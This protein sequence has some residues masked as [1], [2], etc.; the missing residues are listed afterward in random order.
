MQNRL[1]QTWVTNTLLEEDIS[2]MQSGYQKKKKKK[3]H[4]SPKA[5]PK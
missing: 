4:K 2:K 1:A 5:K 3:C